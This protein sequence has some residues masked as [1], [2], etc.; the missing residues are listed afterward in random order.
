MHFAKNYLPHSKFT[1]TGGWHRDCGGELN[2]SE[3]KD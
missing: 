3:C 2:Y 1:R